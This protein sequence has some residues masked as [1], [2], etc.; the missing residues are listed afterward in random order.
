M[1]LVAFV[2]LL[3]AVSELSDLTETPDGITVSGC[4]I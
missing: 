2:L 3:Q 4:G 1:N